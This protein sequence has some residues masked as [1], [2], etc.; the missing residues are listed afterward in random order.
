LE[1]GIS[2]DNRKS[3]KLAKKVGFRKEGRSKR[4]LFLNSEW[5]DFMIYALTSEE[6]S[7]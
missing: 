7:H 2:P 1:A 4:R 6:F 5:K 3:I